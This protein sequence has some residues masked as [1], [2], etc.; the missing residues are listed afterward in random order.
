[1]HIAEVRA[2]LTAYY[3]EGTPGQSLFAP[4]RTVTT[5]HRLGIVT[6]DEVDYQIVDIGMRMLEP[7]EL[8]R[9]QFGPYAASYD[10]SAART[11]SGKVR[12]IG[13]SVVPL[14]AEA[15]VRANVVESSAQEVG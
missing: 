3:R 15:L 6:V 9:A 5:K 1:M 12:L 2:F 11:K 13:N 8:L 10:L 4:L 7:H 14:M